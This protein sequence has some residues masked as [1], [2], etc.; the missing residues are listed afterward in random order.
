MREWQLDAEVTI[1]ASGSIS[2]V[3]QDARRNQPA[4]MAELVPWPSESILIYYSRTPSPSQDDTL[5]FRPD[6]PLANEPLSCEF[7]YFLMA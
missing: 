1:R 2:R 4:P 6:M 5:M 7:G 3:G